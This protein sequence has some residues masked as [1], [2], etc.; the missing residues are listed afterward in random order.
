MRVEYICV[1]TYTCACQG[2]MCEYSA[3]L[4][5]SRTIR[6]ISFHY[7]FSSACLFTCSQMNSR[8]RASRFFFESKKNTTSQSRS[9]YLSTYLSYVLRGK[10]FL[11]SYFFLSISLSCLERRWKKKFFYPF[12]SH[13]LHI[14][15]RTWTLPPILLLPLLLRE[16]QSIH[17]GLY[18]YI[19][20]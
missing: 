12:F 8:S 11:F 16:N 10:V 2:G 17:L 5:E 1:D 19:Y 13:L 18:I 9:I 14:Y 20:T 4:G 6:S 15:C 3:L 7:E